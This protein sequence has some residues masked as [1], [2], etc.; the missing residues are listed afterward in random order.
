MNLVVMFRA[1]ETRASLQH[2]SPTNLLFEPCRNLPSGRCSRNKVIF[3]KA[4]APWS[5]EIEFCRLTRMLVEK[6]IGEFEM[7]ARLLGRYQRCQLL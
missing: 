6:G 2:P 3:Q 1:Q 5:F 7:G 4:A